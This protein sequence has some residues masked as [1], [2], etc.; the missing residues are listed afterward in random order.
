MKTFARIE[1]G[2]VAE[3]IGPLTFDDGS[4][5]PMSE[6]FP[7]SVFETMVDITDV[8]PPPSQGWTYDGATF[9]APAEPTAAQLLATAQANQC[10]AIDAAYLE[11]VQ[12]S[13]S[14]KT[15]AGV[16]QTFQADTDSQTILSQAEQGY[17]IVGAVPANFF[18]K[19]ADNT[20][21][22]FTLADLQGL[23][24]AMLAQGWAAFQ[25]RA[26]LKAQ[27]AAATKASDVAGITWS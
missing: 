3:I 18:W 27:I 15:S 26:T 19:A 5:I 17:A 7:V 11:A 10:A 13:V 25:K 6:R 24:L 22:A 16:T 23:Y 21:V 4:E 14:F 2:V 8:S 1:S 12:V 9:S 20:L